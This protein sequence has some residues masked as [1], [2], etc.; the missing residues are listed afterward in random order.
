[1]E[2]TRLEECLSRMPGAVRD[3]KEEWSWHRWQVG[4]KMFAAICTPGSDHK[5]PY[6]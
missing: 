4:G 6:A 5:A 2:I 1:M 3:Y